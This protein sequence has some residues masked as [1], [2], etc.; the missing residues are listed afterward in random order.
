MA[1]TQ[2]LLVFFAL[3]VGPLACP[4]SLPQGM[5]APRLSQRPQVCFMTHTKAGRFTL[6]ALA[7]YLLQ[8]LTRI[9]QLQVSMAVVLQLTQVLRLI[10]WGQAG[11]ICLYV[12]A[13]AQ[14]VEP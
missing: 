11:A 4:H 10:V 3:T 12:N 6:S 13:R 5:L 14:D 2:R 7:H 8:Y 1:Q 9:H